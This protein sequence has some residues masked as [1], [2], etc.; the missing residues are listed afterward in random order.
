[1]GKSSV[2]VVGYVDQQIDA[3]NTHVPA[4]LGAFDAKGIHQARVATRRLKAAL[5]LLEPLL[6]KKEIEPTQKAGKK[7]RRRLGPLRDLDVMI[8]HLETLTAP[9]K[10]K[11]SAAWLR[12]RLEKSRLQRRQ[13]DYAEGRKPTKLLREFA[14]WHIA[15]H[16]LPDDADALTP[17]VLS[18]L[19]EQF[20]AFVLE[21]D[22]VAG[23]TPP[24]GD[25]PIDIHVLRVNGKNLRYT[26]E[27]AVA[28][29]LPVP[30]HVLKTF[31]AMQESLG[32]WH[33]YVVLAEQAL[34]ATLEAQLSHHSPDLAAAKLDLTK[35][36][37]NQA[38]RALSQFSARWRRSAESLTNALR[39]SVP[40][41]V[42]VSTP[43]A[44]TESQTDLDPPATDAPPAPA[45]FPPDDVPDTQV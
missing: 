40:L 13:D 7:L 2:G 11:A 34:Q 26:F 12:D 43:P 33:D 6:H 5:D 25:D 19:H 1:M 8:D 36:F 4:A 32:T 27:I 18:T 41:T 20:D 14:A 17:H 44:A 3:L 39:E 28:Q 15:R 21:A 29:D 38:G 10:L 42:D 24:A 23:V 30:A 16:S 45:T 35:L 22:Q 9:P 37:L 31:K